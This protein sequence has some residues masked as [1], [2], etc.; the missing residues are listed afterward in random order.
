[1]VRWEWQVH[2]SSGGFS[3]C[4]DAGGHAAMQRGPPFFP[5]QLCLFEKKGES[6]VLGTPNDAASN[7]GL[8]PCSVS[9]LPALC[10]PFSP[11]PFA[12]RAPEHPTATVACFRRRPPPCGHCGRRSPLLSLP[13]TA[14]PSQSVASPVLALQ[15]QDVAYSSSTAQ[16]TRLSRSVKAS[17]TPGLAWLALGIVAVS[18]SNFSFLSALR[19]IVR[20]S[21]FD[22]SAGATRW[23]RIWSPSP[24]SLPASPLL[25]LPRL[26][27]TPLRS[28]SVVPPSIRILV[29]P[30]LS[31]PHSLY[32]LHLRIH[33]P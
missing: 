12:R 32:F 15:R 21:G 28:A 26:N 8:D 27:A 33:S 23:T 3:A 31:T 7:S 22:S 11:L 30:V 18:S 13:C 17:S 29:L 4:V 1:M 24:L 10:W 25:R 19:L 20:P 2:E 6:K 16:G 9:A 14:P 5:L